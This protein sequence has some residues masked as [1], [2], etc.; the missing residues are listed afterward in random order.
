[1][2]G[3]L[4]L[5]MSTVSV[6]MNILRDVRIAVTRPAAQAE[7]LAQPLRELGAQVVITPLIRIV[8]TGDNEVLRKAL[9]ELESFDWI[10]FSSAN[11]VD[12]FVNALRA[13]G[14]E[15]SALRG[16]IACVGP[17]TAAA[18]RSYG[19]QTSVMPESFVGE[20]I[21]E[22]LSAREDLAGRR[23]LIA[24][25]G[26]ARQELPARLAAT[27]AIVADVELYRSA[28]DEE[29]ARILR[30]HIYK[31]AVDVVTFTA[32]SAVRHFVQEVGDPGSTLIAVIGPVTAEAARELGLDV[33]IEAS[34]HTAEG[35]VAAIAKHFAATRG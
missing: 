15:L 18:A 25:A 4:F 29:G 34:S 30:E 2:P 8:A 22:A 35:L 17:A 33:H 9:H 13:A 23:V 31:G 11:G 27:G 6:W 21:A 24:R 12:V 28:V 10:I 7:E 26:G 5:G 1:M 19:L 16:S 3:E 32:A 14:R 20:A